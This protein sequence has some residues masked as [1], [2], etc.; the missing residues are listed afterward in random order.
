MRA[1]GCTIE[2]NESRDNGVEDSESANGIYL[3]G[4]SDNVLHRNRVHGNEDS[5][6]QLTDS[7]DCVMYLNSSWDNGENGFGHLGS[8]GTIHVRDVA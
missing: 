6:I 1:D 8:S 4:A 2:D 3:S 7:D 5:G